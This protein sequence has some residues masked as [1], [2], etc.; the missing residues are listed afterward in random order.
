MQTKTDF[1]RN[2]ETRIHKY[3][4]SCGRIYPYQLPAARISFGSIEEAE[5]FN[6]KHKC[7]IKIFFN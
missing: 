3:E 4:E 5:R 6:A 2:V 7:I 1:G